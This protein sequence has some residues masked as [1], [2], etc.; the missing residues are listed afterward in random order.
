LAVS[1]KFLNVI[2]AEAGIQEMEVSIWIPLKSFSSCPGLHSE[3]SGVRCQVSG[4]G[5]HKLQIREA[6]HLKPETRHLTPE[7]RHLKPDT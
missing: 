4:Y 2:P 6:R 1:G 7:T 3:V 5:E